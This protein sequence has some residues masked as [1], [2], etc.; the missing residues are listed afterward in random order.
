[1]LFVQKC[2]NTAKDTMKMFGYSPKVKETIHVEDQASE[3]IKQIRSDK[4]QLEEDLVAIQNK[5]DVVGIGVIITNIT[6]LIENVV[7]FI[8]S[9]RELA[10]ISGE[11]VKLKESCLKVQEWYLKAEKNERNRAHYLITINSKINE[12]NLLESKVT[13]MQNDNLKKGFFHIITGALSLASSFL[14][15][16]SAPIQIGTMIT[17]G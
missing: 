2:L 10:K 3:I 5:I 8:K 12:L 17:G 7:Y 14:V 4:V 16:Y 15:P 1:M 6:L 13:Y 9:Q 11:L